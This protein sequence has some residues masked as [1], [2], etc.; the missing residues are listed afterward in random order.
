MKNTAK[1]PKFK[2]AKD[3]KNIGIIPIQPTWLTGLKLIRLTYLT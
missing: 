3:E 1:I 2:K